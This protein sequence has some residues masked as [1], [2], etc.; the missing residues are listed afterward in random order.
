MC[1]ISKQGS[2]ENSN[3]LLSFVY[4]RDL[5]EVLVIKKGIRHKAQGISFVVSL[6]DT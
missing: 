6:R 2:D 3:K 4:R 1:K 5:D